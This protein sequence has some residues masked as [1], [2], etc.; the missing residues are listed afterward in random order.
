MSETENVLFR[1]KVKSVNVSG[2]ENTGML[3]LD[4]D[5]MA[6]KARKY[7]AGTELVLEEAHYY[8]KLKVFR[9]YRSKDAYGKSKSEI[10]VSIDDKPFEYFSEDEL[11]GIEEI[12]G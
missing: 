1:G 11:E 3:H 5:G 7:P 8:G 4:E 2:T 9:G 10:V 6:D 12:R